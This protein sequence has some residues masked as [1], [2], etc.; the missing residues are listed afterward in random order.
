M[1]MALMDLLG[2]HSMDGGSHCHAGLGPLAP[3]GLSPSTGERQLQACVL[4]TL[5]GHALP[6]LREAG[7]VQACVD[8]TVRLARDKDTAI[9]V[10]AGRAAARLGVGEPSALAG[11]CGMC[12]CVC[13][14]GTSVCSC[15]QV[16]LC[17]CTCVF[18]WKSIHACVSGEGEASGAEQQP[19][20][21][22]LVN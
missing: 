15:V 6:K 2:G 20:R 16:P 4:A 14:S 13:V 21:Y 7:Q 22:T 12:V 3:S 18:L 11:V 19:G 17:V 8:A 1:D 5:A 10:A 9:K